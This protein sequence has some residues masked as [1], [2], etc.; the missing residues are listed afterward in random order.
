MASEIRTLD[1]STRGLSSGSVKR[2][3]LDI[4][5]GAEAVQATVSFTLFAEG[6]LGDGPAVRIELAFPAAHASPALGLQRA[7][8]THARAV[9][10]RVV[11][12]APE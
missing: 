1:Y 2:L 9:L 3:A 12:I 8:L 6:G 5:D 7:A 10:E 11:A 4:I